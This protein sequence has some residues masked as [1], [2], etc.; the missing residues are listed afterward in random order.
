MK[1][2][3][4]KPHIFIRPGTGRWDWTNSPPRSSAKVSAHK[5]PFMSAIDF[6]RERNIKENRK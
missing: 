2:A 4:S 6:C 5:F 3:M 1:P